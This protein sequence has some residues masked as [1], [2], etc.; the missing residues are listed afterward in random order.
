MERKHFRNI[1]KEK[2]GTDIFYFV[3]PNLN[4]GIKKVHL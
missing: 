3:N 1:L 2:S 4:A